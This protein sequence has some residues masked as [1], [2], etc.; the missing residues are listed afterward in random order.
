MTACRELRSQAHELRSIEAESLPQNAPRA[1]RT[2]LR[3]TANR[4]EDTAEL[5]EREVDRFGLERRFVKGLTTAG[6]MAVIGLASVSGAV[7]TGAAEGGTS[8]IVAHRL[9][10][11]ERTIL[12]RLQEVERECEAL[13]APELVRS[14]LRY[15]IAHRRVFGSD[16][17]QS[18]TVVEAVVG[19]AEF[20]A[21]PAFEEGRR[22]DTRTS[23]RWRSSRQATRLGQG[24]HYQRGRSPRATCGFGDSGK[25]RVV[26]G[27]YAP[28]ARVSTA[29]DWVLR[30][31]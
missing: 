3:E 7:V 25:R 29:A 24:L 2:H 17:T 26:P 20:S 19:A 22:R 15:E 9:E 30:W 31:Q 6:R 21:E 12:E 1:L 4:I 27:G 14:G 8:A 5:L 23:Q 16:P 18:D 10:T 13:R 28:I 11:A